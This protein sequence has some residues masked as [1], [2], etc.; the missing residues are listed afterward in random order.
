MAR[1]GPP[2]SPGNVLE[3][4]ASEGLADPPPEEDISEIGERLGLPLE[5]EPISERLTELRQYER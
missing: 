2:P 5:G 4:L 3:Q 1:L